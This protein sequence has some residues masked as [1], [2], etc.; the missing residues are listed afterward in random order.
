M[1]NSI[2]EIGIILVIIV[3]IFG[4]LLQSVENNTEKVITTQESNNI[5]KTISEVADNLINNPGQ[6]ENWNEYSYGTPGLAIINDDGVTV[7]NSISYSK[8]ISLGDDYQKLVFEN[9]FNSKIQSS[10]ELIPKESSISS[11]KI[12]SDYEGDNIISV[13]RL[14]KCDFYKSY[15][16]KDFQNEGKCNHDHDQS[17][18]SCNY[19]KIFPGNFKKS[20]YYLLIDDSEKYDLEYIID[21]TRVVKAR[22]WQTSIS[23][24]IYLNNEIDFYD[25]DS[26]IVFV[27]LNKEN[28]KA[29][30]VSVPKDFDRNYLNYDY[31]RTNEC[32]F[33]LNAWF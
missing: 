19:F 14:V 10:M 16:L 30:L 6:P 31:F 1:S 32:Q 22:H 9:L 12:G 15:V 26:A 28:A 5:E 24:R 17:K 13:N 8:F 23:N 29:V 2:L 25:D 21:T 3:I 7:P 11:V 18:N 33:I 4:I 27:H 20:D